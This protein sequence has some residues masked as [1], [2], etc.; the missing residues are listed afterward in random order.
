MSDWVEPLAP[1]RIESVEFKADEDFVRIYVTMDG[2]EDKTGYIGL[3]SEETWEFHSD[4]LPAYDYDEKKGKYVARTLEYPNY[5]C[6]RTSNNESLFLVD[7]SEIPSGKVVSHPYLIFSRNDSR[8]HRK[9]S[10]NVKARSLSGETFLYMHNLDINSSGQHD[11]F[12]PNPG[13]MASNIRCESDPALKVIGHVAA[14]IVSSK[15]VFLDS[16]FAKEWN[17]NVG[18]L[19]LPNPD[20]T[21]SDLLER[22]FHPIDYMNIYDDYY[23]KVLYGMAWG[24]KRC[25]DCIEAGGT[26]EK[27]DF[28]E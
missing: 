7:Y 26:K 14:S 16:R 4:F 20:N 13:E 12:R 10:I 3:T 1:P 17:P 5:W 9:Y 23:A 18:N 25:Y 28:W 11:L 19:L 8:N 24:P 2:G 15:R 21:I 27:P 22:S 6:W